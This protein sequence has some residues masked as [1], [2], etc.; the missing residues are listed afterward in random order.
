MSRKHQVCHLQCIANNELIANKRRTQE[1]IAFSD[2]E[3]FQ[4]CATISFLVV[5]YLRRSV[6][7]LFG[8][9]LLKCS[10]LRLC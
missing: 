8:F 9:T 7:K 3:H 6:E 1:E 5:S 10:I 2:V 4:Y